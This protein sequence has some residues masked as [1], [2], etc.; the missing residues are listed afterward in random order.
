[1]KRHLLLFFSVLLVLGAYNRGEATHIRAGEVT[2][3]L[4]SC[5]NYTYRFTITGYTDLGS[6]VK[7]GG[8]E[9][10][11]GDGVIETFETDKPDYEEDL[12]DLRAIVI[13]YKEHTFPGPGIYKVSFR[14]F[15]R[16]EGIVNMDN[17][18]Q[19]PFY[20]ETEIKID[21]FFGCNNTPVLLNPPIDDAC[22]GVTYLHN[23]GAIDVDG[24]SLSYEITT[25]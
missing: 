25:T 15:N 4:I 11:F 19:T 5:Q 18:V 9:I 12:G 22:V 13:F 23:A 3:T 8:G 6:D 17:S 21:P 10:N 20:V 2:A 16:N 7:F 24:D 1:M 14:E